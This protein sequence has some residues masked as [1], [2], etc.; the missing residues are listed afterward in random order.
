MK[1]IFFPALTIGGWLVSSTVTHITYKNVF[2]AVCNGDIN[3]TQ[4]IQGVVPLSFW[5]NHIKCQNE[6]LSESLDNFSVDVLRLLV[7]QR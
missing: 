3:H 2:C 6:T 1:F 5:N 7:K 4:V